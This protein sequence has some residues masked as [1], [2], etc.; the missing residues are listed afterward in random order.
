MQ[1][2]RA[3][4]AASGKSIPFKIAPRRAGDIDSYFANAE[5][6]KK[7]LGWAAELTIEDMCRSSLNFYSK[8]KI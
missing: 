7:E 1:I 6:A 3:F 4:E 8:R 5:K 2:L